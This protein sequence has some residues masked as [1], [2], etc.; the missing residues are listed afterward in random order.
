MSSV[1]DMG[2]SGEQDGLPS[3]R[4]LTVYLFFQHGARTL[5]L[6]S[7]DWGFLLLEAPLLPYSC[8]SS[9]ILQ[10]LIQMSVPHDASSL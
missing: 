1:L 7:F 4:E 6:C 2:Y 10:G 9:K 5:C 8:S 3:H